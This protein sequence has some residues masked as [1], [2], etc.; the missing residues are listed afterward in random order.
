MIVKSFQAAASN[1]GR[2]PTANSA[3]FMREAML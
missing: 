2:H 1:N 3:A